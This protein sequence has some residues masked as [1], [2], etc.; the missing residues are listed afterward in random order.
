MTCVTNTRYKYRKRSVTTV[1]KPPETII[2][3]FSVGFGDYIAYLRKEQDK[4]IEE[5]SASTGLSVLYLRNVESGRQIPT[6]E[7][8]EKLAAPLGTTFKNLLFQ[9][10]YVEVKDIF[11]FLHA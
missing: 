11:S 4:T 1:T 10:G 7:E 6:R 3:D 2:D 9:A 5:I 8:L